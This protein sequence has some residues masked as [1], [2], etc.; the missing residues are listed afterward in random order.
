MDDACHEYTTQVIGSMKHRRI[1]HNVGLTVNRRA[2]LCS[3]SK[4]NPQGASRQIHHSFNDKTPNPSDVRLQW[5]KC[6][7]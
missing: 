5:R 4:N 2:V 1:L 3:G 6:F 7:P